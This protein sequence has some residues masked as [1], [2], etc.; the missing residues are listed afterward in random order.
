MAITVDA[1]D[2]RI[3]EFPDVEAA[4]QFFASQKPE[5][6]MVESV[7]DWFK[8][9]NRREDIPQAIS[10]K[11]GL[12]PAKSAEMTALLA[13]TASDDRLQR[14]ISKIEPAAQFDKDEFGN[15]IAV[16]PVR[17]EKGEVTAI[18]PAGPC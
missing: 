11:L 8:G 13:T 5:K 12:S 15:L 14:G 3:I 9:V 6:G 2:G 18:Q 16:M 4:N 7:V 1:G 10:A 17:N